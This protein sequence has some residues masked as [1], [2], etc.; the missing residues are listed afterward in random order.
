ML[1]TKCVSVIHMQIGSIPNRVNE[2][3]S[4]LAIVVVVVVVTVVTVVVVVV[5][6][7]VLVSSQ[8]L[9]IAAD[10]KSGGR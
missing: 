3:E 10:V 4:S 1:G 5:S 2:K 8:I 7:K 9:A 6:S